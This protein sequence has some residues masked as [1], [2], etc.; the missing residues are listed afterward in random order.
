MKRG[1]KA[2]VYETPEDTVCPN[3]G[4]PCQIVPLLNHF[5]YSGTHCTHGL[6]GVHYPDDWGWPGSDC[7]EAR[8]EA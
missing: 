6:G 7:C 8:M 4:E 5:D 2:P 1:H 3:C